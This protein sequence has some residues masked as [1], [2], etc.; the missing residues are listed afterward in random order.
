MGQLGVRTGQGEMSAQAWPL[1]DAQGVEDPLGFAPALLEHKG[2][3]AAVTGSGAHQRLEVGAVF[4]MQH[5]L[6]RGMLLQTSGQS[7]GVAIE[8]F[9]PFRRIA[10]GL[11]EGDGIG[12]AEHSGGVHR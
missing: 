10:A 1:A 2:Q 3:E 12:I 11:L 6:D 9:D 4:G 7:Q 5:L 8:A